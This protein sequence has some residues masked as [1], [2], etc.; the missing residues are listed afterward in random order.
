ME[1]LNLALVSSSKPLML[2]HVPARDATDRDVLRRKPFSLGRVLIAPHRFRYRVSALSSSHHSP[3]SGIQ[4]LNF[5]FV[6]L[7]SFCVRACVF[8]GGL[9]FWLEFIFGRKEIHWILMESNKMK[10]VLLKLKVN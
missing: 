4:F 5:F 1:N 6:L 9:E 7:L 3:K 2:G 8:D 10:C